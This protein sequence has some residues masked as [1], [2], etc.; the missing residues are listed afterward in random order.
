MK[1]VLCKLHV[2]AEKIPDQCMIVFVDVIDRDMLL[3]SFKKQGIASAGCSRNVLTEILVLEIAA[4][5]HVS[6]YNE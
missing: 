4:I 1:T 5:H 3:L 2:R 6:V